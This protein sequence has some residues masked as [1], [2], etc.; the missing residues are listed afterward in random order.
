MGDFGNSGDSNVNWNANGRRTFGR[1]CSIG[2]LDVHFHKIIYFPWYV[3]SFGRGLGRGLIIQNKGRFSISLYQ[4]IPILNKKYPCTALEK[5]LFVQN[6]SSMLSEGLNFHFI[7][8][9]F[10]YSHNL[11]YV[12]R[13]STLDSSKFANSNYLKLTIKESTVCCPGHYNSQQII[14]NFGFL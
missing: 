13:Q 11:A 8:F 7:W 12:L 9:F 14:I 4:I 6:L 10:A 5:T 1:M 3:L 2:N